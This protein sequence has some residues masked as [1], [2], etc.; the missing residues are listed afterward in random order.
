MKGMLHRVLKNLS[1]YLDAPN[2]R[3]KAAMTVLR[4]VLWQANK[5]LLKMRRVYQ[6]DDFK[7]CLY[8]DCAISALIV[9]QKYPD[10]DQWIFFNRF[11]TEFHT[12]IDI[13]ATTVRS[14]ALDNY[15]RSIETAGL[16]TPVLIK[17]D[18]EGAELLALKGMIKTIEAYRP[19]FHLEANHLSERHGYTRNEMYIFLYNLG[20]K[21]YVFDGKNQQ[22]LPID[23][24][25]EYGN[26]IA[27][28]E[29]FQLIINDD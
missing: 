1:G 15:F 28:P 7:I 4:F 2:N 26:V 16:E 17:L 5:R 29:D 12:F 8:P 14:A 25:N 18:I 3:G 11:M 27:I 22:F 10:Y 19:V 21:I 9:Y 20:Y 13:G 23:I 24:D 6:H